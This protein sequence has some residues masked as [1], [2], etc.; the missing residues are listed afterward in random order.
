MHEKVDGCA[1]DEVNGNLQQLYGPELAA[2][3]GNLQDD[4]GHVEDKGQLAEGPRRIE[5]DNEGHAG[6]GRRPQAGD[7]NQVDAEGRHQDTAKKDTDPYFQ[8]MHMTHTQSPHFFSF[9]IMR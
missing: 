9:S 2:Q 1:E 5:A 4:E 7:S 8:M 3:Q 6:N